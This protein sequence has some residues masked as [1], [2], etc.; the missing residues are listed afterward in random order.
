MTKNHLLD[1]YNIPE[2][3]VLDVLLEAQDCSDLQQVYQT[4]TREEIKCG[5]Q[6]RCEEERGIVE[7]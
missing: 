2:E 1:V 6:T 5:R 7:S 4:C 3:Y